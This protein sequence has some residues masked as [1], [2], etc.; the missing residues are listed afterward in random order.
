MVL[1]N[2]HQNERDASGFALILYKLDRVVSPATKQAL[3]LNQDLF[4]RV[5]MEIYGN[6]HVSP[7]FI[8]KWFS[9]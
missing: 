9:S 1:L 3:A 2:R 4:I 6:S 7:I 5:A 8:V